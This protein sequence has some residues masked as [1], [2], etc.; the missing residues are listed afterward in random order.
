MGIAFITIR[1]NLCD[2]IYLYYVFIYIY[3]YIWGIVIIC[4]LLGI[5][6]RMESLGPCVE[7]YIIYY[8]Y[9]IHIIL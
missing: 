4:S 8:E 5:Q 6:G 7:F 3:I 2:I 1:C 9:N